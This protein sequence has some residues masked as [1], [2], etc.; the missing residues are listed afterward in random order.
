MKLDTM[1]KRSECPNVIR[2][3][4]YHHMEKT[5]WLHITHII[6]ILD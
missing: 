4:S 2:K 1:T 6:Y 5:N 3:G